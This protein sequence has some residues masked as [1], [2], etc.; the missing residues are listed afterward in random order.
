MNND[1][2]LD[3]IKVIREHMKETLIT[4]ICEELNMG[5]LNCKGHIFLGYL[6]WYKDLIDF[7]KKL[8]KKK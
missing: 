8:S 2:V 1:K 7:G 5:C 6:E 4:K 3:A